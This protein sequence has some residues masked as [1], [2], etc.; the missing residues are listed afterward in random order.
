MTL[1]HA[2]KVDSIEIHIKTHAI[3]STFMQEQTIVSKD[4]F[5]KLML[6]QP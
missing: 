6:L 1:H 4:I 5:D 2:S 3:D